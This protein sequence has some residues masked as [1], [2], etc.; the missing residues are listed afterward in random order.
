MTTPAFAKAHALV[1]LPVSTSVDFRHTLAEMG[2]HFGVRNELTR[3]FTEAAVAELFETY[4]DLDGL[5]GAMGEAVPGKRSTWYREAIVP[6][7][8]ASG[9]NPMFLVANWM[10]PFDDFLADIA[11]KQIYG[12]TWLSLHSN[13]EMFTDAKPYPTYVRWLEQGNVP[14]VMEVMHHNIEGAFPFNSP[15]L[16]WETVHEFR[17]FENCRGIL[18]WF[19]IDNPN[20]LMRKA[21]AYYA[22]NPVDYSD[23]P[24]L[25]ELEKRF[26]NRQ[27]A[28]HFLK[29]YDASARIIPEVSALACVPH[30][31]GTSRALLLPYWYWTDDDPR[32]NELVSPARA[33][34][35]LAVRSYARIVARLGPQF[36]DNSGS[37]SAKNREHPGSQELIWGLGIIR[38][39]P[40]PTC[41]ASPARRR[42]AA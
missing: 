35:L 37:D 5:H 15:R 4:P 24:W 19:T 13:A 40:K 39:R 8:K 29:A 41:A 22:E 31:L 10:Q 2:P 30:D 3:A 12:N 23:E 33:G 1:G 21:L 17:Q 20:A 18:A 34:V 9:R 42:S 6:G 27:A 11:P 32:W 14:T 36:R 25:I 26:G 16:A 28:A 38:R 7:L